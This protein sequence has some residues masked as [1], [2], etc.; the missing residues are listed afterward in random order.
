M[1]RKEGHSD[2]LDWEGRIAAKREEKG[3]T[4]VDGQG[5]VESGGTAA[6]R[7]AAGEWL[8]RGHVKRRHCMQN[9]ESSGNDFPP[10]PLHLEAWCRAWLAMWLHADGGPAAQLWLVFDILE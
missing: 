5:G 3:K 4:A 1:Y 2:V 7:A 9:A 10:N 8:S 6:G